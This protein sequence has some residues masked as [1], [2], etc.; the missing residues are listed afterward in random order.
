[1]Y[2]DALPNEILSHVYATLPNIASVLALA[3]T[4]KHLHTVYHSSQ[5]LSLLATVADTEFGPLDDIIQ[6]CTHN[7]SQPAHHHRT[8]ALSTA[9]LTQIL[10]IGRTAL[11]WED[12]YPF[13]KWKSDFASRRLLSAPE[14]RR[15][16]RAL[17]RLWLYSHAFHTRDYPRTTR[18]HPATIA[19]RAA[20]L[21][22]WTT[23]DLAAMWDVH[24]VIRDVVA[25][26]V[27]PS[28][29]KIAAKFSKRYPESTHQLLFNIHYAPPPAPSFCAT[30]AW[31][32]TPSLKYPAVSNSNRLQP[33]RF[34]E[35][36][37]EGWGDEIQHYYV[38]ED[39]MK[40]DPGQILFLRNFCSLKLHVQAWIRMNVPGAAE[41]FVEN[42]ET[43]SE[44]VGV[45]VR[46]RGGEMEEFRV[47]VE[48]GAMGV[49]LAAS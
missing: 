23:A 17:Y 21:H 20:L 40:L 38:V 32:S 11:A 30:E 12:I 34:H 6:I 47:G 10:S 4:C 33:T 44:T 1:M 46:Q 49:A 28:N 16:R 15:L 26:N 7:A 48:E 42:G 25:N 41:W 9:L 35:P 43:F 18:N 19:E 14:R 24:V 2:F 37:G 31:F 39:M 22:N 36:G 3:S 29:G 5:R 13:K 45:V 27:C 8:A